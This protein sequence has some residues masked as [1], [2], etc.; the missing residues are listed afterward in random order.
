MSPTDPTATLQAAAGAA[1]AVEPRPGP[2]S[3]PCNRRPP[4]PLYLHGVARPSCVL[5]PERI[6]RPTATIIGPTPPARCIA[7]RSPTPRVSQ[8]AKWEKV[9]G[10]VIPRAQRGIAALRRC[11]IRNDWFRA[12]HPRIRA[13][14]AVVTAVAAAAY[15]LERQRISSLLLSD[16]AALRKTAWKR[17]SASPPQPFAHFAARFAAGVARWPRPCVC[18][19]CVL[20]FPATAPRSTDIV[21]AV[22]DRVHSIGDRRRSR[23]FTALPTDLSR[24]GTRPRSISRRLHDALTSASARALAW[25]A[26]TGDAAW[27][28]RMVRRIRRAVG[29]R[30]PQ[31]RRRRRRLAS[32]WARHPDPSGLSSSRRYARLDALHQLRPSMPSTRMSWSQNIS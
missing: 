8:T 17:L 27:R 24:I 28:Y 9:F 1:Q 2:T 6:T 18:E 22:S 31:G 23:F 14:V 15:P 3:T 12:Q 20:Q 4:A 32:S 13:A 30:R 16:R 26:R 19:P 21:E 7:R 11:P 29:P 25:P 10:E 5:R